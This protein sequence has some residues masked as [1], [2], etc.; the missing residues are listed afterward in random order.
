MASP[1]RTTKSSGGLVY[2]TE[3]GRI[4]P[5]CRQGVAQCRCAR[6]AAV[7]AGDGIVRVSRD[8]K[9]RGGKVVTVIRGLDLDAPALNALG[10]ELKA[11]CGTG[12]TVKDGAIELQGDHCE[13]AI[14]ALRGR[15]RQVK[16]AGG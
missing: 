11:L 14:A 4:C 8:A 1:I 3:V 7:P 9:G 13:R 2:S 6:T 5:E 15:G 16:R 12:G 10:K